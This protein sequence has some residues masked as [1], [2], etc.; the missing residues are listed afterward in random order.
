MAV[1]G[2]EFGESVEDGHDGGAIA[3]LTGFMNA[4][5]TTTRPSPWEVTSYTAD[6]QRYHTTAVLA[7]FLSKTAYTTWKTTSGFQTWWEGLK[8]ETQ[9]HGWFLEVFFPSIERVETISDG[10]WGVSEGVARM[11]MGLS[12]AVREHGYWGSMGDRL[13][14]S[15]DDGLVGEPRLCG[16]E[17]D[18]AAAA[19]GG[20]GNDGGG[21]CGRIRIPEN[22]T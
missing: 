5:G 7:Y 14:V 10:D 15:Q 13:P 19:A 11:G 17:P 8:P 9:R 22:K 1:I 20:D 18:Y 16:K 4:A 12:A 3:H 6:N 21:R 2:A